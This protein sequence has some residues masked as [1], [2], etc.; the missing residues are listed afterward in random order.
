[1]NA[2][3]RLLGTSE[4]PK[5]MIDQL[6]RCDTVGPNDKGQRISRQRNWLL[7][8]WTA[9]LGVL[10]MPIENFVHIVSLLFKMNHSTLKPEAMRSLSQLR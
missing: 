6:R 5:K 3:S 4:T 8:R 7:V 1:M 10:A 9:L 2:T